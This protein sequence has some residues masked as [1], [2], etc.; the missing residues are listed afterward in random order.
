ALR[1]RQ[2]LEAE[3]QLLAGP[4]PE[5]EVLA[6]RRSRGGGGAALPPPGLRLP[7]LAALVLERV[8]RHLATAPAQQVDHPVMRK[9]EEPGAEGRALRRRAR[10]LVP[11]LGP[12]VLDPLVGLGR[13]RRAEEAA[14]EAVEARL[15][16]RVELLERA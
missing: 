15:V 11:A 3:Q 10:A 14:D 13:E 8:D 9:G 1:Q 6:L 5:R 12:G 2:L 7:R 16:T 4:P